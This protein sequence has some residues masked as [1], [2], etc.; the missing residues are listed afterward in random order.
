MCIRD[1]IFAGPIADVENAYAA[2]DLFVFLPLY[3]PSANVCLEALAAGLPV[4]TTVQNGAAEWLEPGVT[5][6]LVPNPAATGDVV[7]AIQFRQSRRSQPRL[8]L[9]LDSFSL[10]RNMAETLAILELAV[11]EKAGRAAS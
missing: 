9:P 7:Q 5:G 10:E 3:E 2:A 8:R 1:R 4:V 11:R 6:T